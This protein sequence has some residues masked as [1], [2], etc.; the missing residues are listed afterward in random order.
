MSILVTDTSA[1]VAILREEPEA[2]VFAKLLE[3]SDPAI[4]AGSVIEAIRAMTA[5]RGADAGARVWLFIRTFR[6]RIVAV[7]AAQVHLAEEGMA[8]FGKGRGAP[9]S[10][11]TA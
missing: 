7:T 10:R 11:S 6:V 4:S 9:P 1:L 3:D 5:K 2:D 8:R